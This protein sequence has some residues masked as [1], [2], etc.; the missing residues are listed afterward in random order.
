LNLLSF[1]HDA[2]SFAGGNISFVTLPIAGFAT[3]GGK[4]VNLVD[5]V[6]VRAE[7]AQ[8][9]TPRS[10]KP[11]PVATPHSTAK[12]TSV[13]TLAPT[14]PAVVATATAA[15]DVSREWAAPVSSGSIPCVK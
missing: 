10:A 4:D 2:Q 3:V 6:Q 8:L 14:N 5:L 7:V 13:S 9:L 15:P 12:P 11:T 1:A